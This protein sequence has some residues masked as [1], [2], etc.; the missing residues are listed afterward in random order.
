MEQ[1]FVLLNLKLN[2]YFEGNYDQGRPSF[3]TDIF[4]AISFKSEIEAKERLFYESI[5]YPEYFKG[6]AFTVVSIYK[7]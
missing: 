7:L 5:D 6:S 2:S 3:T 4:E 1:E